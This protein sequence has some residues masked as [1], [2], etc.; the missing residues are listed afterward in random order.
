MYCLKV[1]LF[2]P[3]RIV[4]FIINEKSN[5]KKQTNLTHVN[6]FRFQL[7]DD[8]RIILSFNCICLYTSENAISPFIFSSTNV[9][10]SLFNSETET[11]SRSR[12]TAVV[13]MMTSCKTPGVTLVKSPVRV[14]TIATVVAFFDWSN[15]IKMA[16]PRM[17]DNVLTVSLLATLS[18]NI[19]IM[20]RYTA[21]VGE[22]AGFTRTLT[23]LIYK[24]NMQQKEERLKNWF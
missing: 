11:V 18:C 15:E 17:S 6:I 5:S 7:L 10:V 24:K 8:C 20:L 4:S 12:V 9:R 3:N 13:D 23:F 2:R 21:S 1:Y 14:F 19:G 16:D 22:D